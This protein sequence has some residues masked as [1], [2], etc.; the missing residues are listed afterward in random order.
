M[1]TSKLVSCAIVLMM[2]SHIA[3]ASTMRCGT[4]IIQVGDTK[5]EVLKHCGE[6][7]LTDLISGLEDIKTEIWYYDRGST[8]FLYIVT[9]RG[10]KVSRIEVKQS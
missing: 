5:I 9:M 4:H 3:A 7:D 1:K 10:S 8:G 6:P 2:I